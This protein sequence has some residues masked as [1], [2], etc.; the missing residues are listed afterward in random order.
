MA[1]RD[2]IGI[3]KLLMDA[4][5]PRLPEVQKSQ[6]EAVRTMARTLGSKLVALCEH[7]V[8]NGL[9]LGDLPIVMEAED[10]PDSYIVLDGNRRLAAI[11]ALES[12]ELVQGALNPGQLKKLKR[13]SREYERKGP[14]ESILCV[15]ADDRKEADPWIRNRH[16]GEGGG[17]GLA[18]WNGIQGARYD[19]RVGKVL[20]HLEVLNFAR[21]HGGLSK[22]VLQKLDTFPITT[23][24]RL[25]NDRD[26]RS[27]I[28]LD[29]V[30]GEIRT[31]YPAEQIAKPLRKMIRDLA[32]GAVTVSDLKRKEH[33]LSYAAEFTASDLPDPRAAGAWRTLTDLPPPRSDTG[34]KGSDKGKRKGDNKKDRDTLLPHDL[35]LKIPEARIADVFTELKRLNADHFKN[36]AGVM[37]RV[38]WEWSIEHYLDAADLRATLTDERKRNLHKRVIVVL[39]HLQNSGRMSKPELKPIRVEMNNEHSLVATDTLHAYVHNVGMVLKPSELRQTWDRMEPVMLKIWG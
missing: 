18:R 8:G 13:L 3:D 32:T 26:I 36:I 1:Y 15:V 19:H 7:I 27:R 30:S 33:R 39:D 4:K 24:Q 35:Q 25:V 38:F 20:P 9:S 11:R 14:V 23:L 22:E 12:P 5:N 29:L 34:A 37:L 21:E 2:E 6:R 31:R 17:A 16:R 10:D 28:G